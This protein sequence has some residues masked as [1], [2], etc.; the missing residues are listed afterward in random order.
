MNIYLLQ[1]DEG[2]CYDSYDSVVVYAHSEEEARLIHPAGNHR[3]GDPYYREGWASSPD[4]VNVTLL[5]QGEGQPGVI[6]ASFNA[7]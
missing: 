6:L 5:G 4:N 2:A 1:S 3:W 7:G